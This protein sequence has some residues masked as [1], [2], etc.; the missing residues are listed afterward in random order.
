[1][2]DNE[3]DYLKEYLTCAA[4]V[5]EALD[6]M[7]SETNTYLLWDCTPMSPG[8]EKEITQN[9][10]KGQFYLLCTS[11]C[12]IQKVLKLDLSDFLTLILQKQ[13]TP[14]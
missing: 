12:S 2:K 7:Q 11:Y 14:Q 9:R 13:N 6:I 10:E 3:F 5:A 1:M 4:P 8:F